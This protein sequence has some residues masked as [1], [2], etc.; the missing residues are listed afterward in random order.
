MS[1][2]GEIKRRRVAQVAVLY[3]VVAWGLVEIV[4]TVEE[5]L[6]LPGWVDTLVIVLVLVGFPLALILSWAFDVTPTGVVRTVDSGPEGMASSQPPLSTPVSTDEPLENSVAV[7]P[8]DNLSPNPDDAY[9][10]AG[11]HEEILTQLAK[12]HALNVI[13]RTSVMQYAS[14]AR[15]ISEIANELRVGAIMEGSVRYAGDRVRV[16]AQLIEAATGTHLWTETYDRDLEDIFAIQSDIAKSIAAAL[17]AELLADEQQSI[18]K[19]PTDSPEAY[20]HYL[21]AMALLQ[22]HGLGVGGT[23][24]LRSAVL[25]SLDEALE[26]DPNF[27][28]A[29]AVRARVNIYVL[30]FDPGS[31]KNYDE[32]RREL[33]DRVLRDLK[34]ALSLD[35]SLAAAHLGLALTHQYNWRLTAT[36]EAFDKALA[37]SPND[38]DVLYNYSNFCGYNGLHDKAIDL[39]K[40]AVT[41]DPG[42]SPRFNFL[43]LTYAVA[44]RLSDA[45]AAARRAVALNPSSGIWLSVLVR[46]EM[47]TGDTESAV[48]HLRAAE[49]LFAGTTNP[50]FIGDLVCAYGL[51]G[52][53]DDA[54]RAFQHL[55]SVAET[56][57]VPPITWVFAYA[58]LEHE[59]EALRWLTETAENPEPYEAYFAVLNTKTN[60]YRVPLFDKPEFAA[61]RER[62]GHHD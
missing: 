9:F 14:V 31:S 38:P 59:A 12:I 7:L 22:E 3:G 30:N 43:S 36:K 40:R 28:A 42:G 6:G 62:L 13:A 32:E 50:V 29:Y 39:G 49:K 53:K 46:M 57:R 58:G 5:P 51:L 16:T 34:R 61:Q 19:P 25:A 18:E 27:A 4:A 21:R 37:L 1:L 35:G 44:G 52:L 8:L 33:E 47:I 60:A 23:P 56:R 24:E 55:E 15:P 17:E 11:I 20:S 10:A 26:I 48:E 2:L 41:L 54:K 45:L